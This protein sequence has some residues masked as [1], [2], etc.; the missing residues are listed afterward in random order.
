MLR[1]LLVALAMAAASVISW[2]DVA[3]AGALYGALT[4]RDRSGPL[5]AGVGAALAWT[6]ILLGDAAV[7]PVGT[8]AATLG[9]V[10]QIRP[11]AVYVVTVAYAALI[12]LCAAVV[13]RAVTR[14][15]RPTSAAR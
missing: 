14:V 9:G 13:A 3:V 5:V 11:V 4:A 12:A 1:T 10:L 15:I 7:G 6:G 8:V 2:W